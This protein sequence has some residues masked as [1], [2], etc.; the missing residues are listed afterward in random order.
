[1]VMGTLLWVSLLVQEL[2]QMDLKV[3]A[4]LRHSGIY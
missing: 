1:M 3:S 4:N 2:D